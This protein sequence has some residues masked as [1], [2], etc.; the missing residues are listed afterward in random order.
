MPYLVH[1]DCRHFRGELPCKPHKQSGVI[2]DGCP[3]YDPFDMRILIVK[4]A[5]AGDVIRTTPL[6]RKLR[7]EHPRAWI[8]WLKR[9]TSLDPPINTV[10]IDCCESS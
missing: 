7:A 6:L 5:A 2:C 4:L 8:T 3:E 1:R 10:F 9:D